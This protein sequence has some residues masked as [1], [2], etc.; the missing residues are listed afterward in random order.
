MTITICKKVFT[1]VE[2]LQC[3]DYSQ[4][5]FKNGPYQTNHNIWGKSVVKDS[6]LV[7]VHTLDNKLPIFKM[8][9][10]VAQDKLNMSPTGISFYAWTPGSY[11]PWHNDDIWGAGGSIYLSPVWE[12]DWGGCFLYLDDNEEIKGLYPE[13]N[14]GVAQRGGVYHH[15]TRLGNNV[16]YRYSIQLF[17]KK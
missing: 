5:I 12:K 13:R 16:P 17:E 7:L 4:Y 15:V 9:F 11:I 14:T 2:Y 3:Y 6:H 8:I 10:N 1:E